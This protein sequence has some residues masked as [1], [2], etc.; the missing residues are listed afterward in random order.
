MQ[1]LVGRFGS[2]EYGTETLETLPL[3]KVKGCANSRSDNAAEGNN[4]TDNGSPQPLPVTKVTQYNQSKKK[5]DAGRSLPRGKRN[6][7]AGDDWPI[8]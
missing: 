7:W 3:E 6:D 8:A 4:G 1:G 2:C 5:G